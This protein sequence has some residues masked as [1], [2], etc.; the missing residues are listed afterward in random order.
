MVTQTEE[1]TTYR[2]T[3]QDETGGSGLKYWF[4]SAGKVRYGEPG[5]TQEI[6]DSLVCL[7][8]RIGCAEGYTDKNGV[9]HNPKLR[10]I[11][12]RVDGREEGISVNLGSVAAK[13]IA[14]ALLIWDEGLFL[15]LTPQ[16]SDKKNKFGKY[17][18]FVSVSECIGPQQYRQLRTTWDERDT[19][20]IVAEVAALFPKLYKDFVRE[21][22][23]DGSAPWD[24]LSAWLEA[25]GWQP[26]T[27]Q[28]PYL[29]IISKAVKMQIDRAV[30]IPPEFWPKAVATFEAAAKKNMIPDICKAEQD[31]EEFDPFADE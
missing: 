27:G 28:K 23:H 9:I 24:A 14:Q 30:A 13:N 10:M 16:Q 6:L 21:D 7:P 2:P 17:S 25:N 20:D 8:K 31:L 1:K 5:D 19:A 22:P 11:V 26:F 29:D 15:R 4:I 3:E 12:E 18:T